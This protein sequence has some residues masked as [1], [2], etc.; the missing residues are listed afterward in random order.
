MKRGIHVLCEKPFATSFEHARTMVNV[1]D[2]MDVVLMMASKFRYAEDIVRAKAMITSGMMGEILFF[3][4]WFGSKINMRNR[5]NSDPA[6]AGGGVLVDN[7]THSVDIVRYLLGPIQ[8][9]QANEGKRPAGLEVED[10]AKISFVTKDQAMGSIHLSWSVQLGPDCYINIVGTEGKICIGWQDSTY[11]HNGHPEWVS[12]G[13][14]YNKNDAFQK[15]LTN[16]L[17]TMT[18]AGEPT[19]SLEDALASVKVI[20][21]AYQ[22]M[23]KQTT[24]I[25]EDPSLTTKSASRK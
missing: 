14:G 15:L 8:S 12:F 11:Q 3:Q 18:G 25:V 2:E 9:V 24:L 23:A 5:W 7:G 10:T 22:S 1:A 17:Q 6:V 13:V 19:I 20:E 4:N 21:T 16:F